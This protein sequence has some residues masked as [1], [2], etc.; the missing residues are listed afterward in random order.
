MTDVAADLDEDIE[1][2][3]YEEDINYGDEDPILAEVDAMIPDSPDLEGF[4]LLFEDRPV[5]V[6]ATRSPRVELAWEEYLEFL[7]KTPGKA[8]RLFEFTGDEARKSAQ[9]R[10]RSVKSRLRR[11]K[12]AD[13]YEVTA[14]EIKGTDTWRVYASYE[15]AATPEEIATRNQM[16]LDSVARGH[17]AADAR[18]AQRAAAAN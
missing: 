14:D 6:K 17:V 9:A 10:A 15:R 5:V 2:D 3:E 13:I 16:H 12:A 4:S 18:K 11:T 8:I 1:E 7:K